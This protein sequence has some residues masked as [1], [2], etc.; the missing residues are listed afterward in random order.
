[1]ETPV[2]W[3][4]NTTCSR[5]IERRHVWLLDTRPWARTGRCKCAGPQR[6]RRTNNGYAVF[7]TVECVTSRCTWGVTLYSGCGGDTTSWS[8]RRDCRRW[9][10]AISL[11]STFQAADD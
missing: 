5:G 11:S 2:S 1:M 4:A 6:R 7:D 9:R 10:V 3:T 8:E